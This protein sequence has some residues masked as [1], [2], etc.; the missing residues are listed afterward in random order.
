MKIDKFH[1]RV[2]WLACVDCGK[3]RWVRILE[4]KPKSIYCHDCSVKRRGYSVVIAYP[5]RS[6]KEAYIQDYGKD[7]ENH[8]DSAENIVCPERIFC[9]D[10]S[11]YCKGWKH[12]PYR[13]EAL[14]TIK[15]KI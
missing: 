1:K 6:V 15:E 13:A 3:E 9:R 14:E 5:R 11:Y 2:I 10:C 12:C 7:L 8:F 4:G